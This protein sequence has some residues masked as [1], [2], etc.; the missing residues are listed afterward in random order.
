MRVGVALWRM[1]LVDVAD[2]A[3]LWLTCGWCLLPPCSLDTR[4]RPVGD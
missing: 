2:V 4:A 3:R 1:W